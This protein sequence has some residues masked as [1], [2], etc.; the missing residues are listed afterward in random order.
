[1]EL[2]PRPFPSGKLEHLPGAVETFVTAGGSSWHKRKG[3]SVAGSLLSPC[4][5]I[6]MYIWCIYDINGNMPTR[7]LRC[8]EIPFL[9]SGHPQVYRSK[10]QKSKNPKNKT[11]KS[12]KTQKQKYN[13]IKKHDKN[14]KQK[15]KNNQNT[16]KTQNLN[17]FSF[18]LVFRCLDLGFWDVRSFWISGSAAL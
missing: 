11:S 17:W 10:I 14:K 9:V 13:R 8:T 1:M 7:H 4:A 2:I 5:I 3:R 16:Q 6:Y 12:Q 18:F 15:S